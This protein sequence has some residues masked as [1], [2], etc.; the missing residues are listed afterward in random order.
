MNFSSHQNNLID[1]IEL[2]LG[3][4][5]KSLINDFKPIL[6]QAKSLYKTSEFDFWLK[7]IGEVNLDELPVTIYGHN[8]AVGVCGYLRNEDKNRIKG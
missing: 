5:K 7:T 8:E 4:D 1:K 6:N 3:K 2:A